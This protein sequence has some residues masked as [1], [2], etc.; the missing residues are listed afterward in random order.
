[1]EN[2]SKALIM[3]G[4][5][6]FTILVVGMM[7][8]FFSRYRELPQKQE[9]ALETEQV[10]KFN[11]EYESYNKKKMYG[12]DV[13]TIWNKAINNNK[14]YTSSINEKDYLEKDYLELEESNYYID[15][16][17]T[18]LTPV[19]SEATRYRETT[20]P[21]GNKMVETT[22]IDNG[23]IKGK[24]NGKGKSKPFDLGVVY[25]SGTPIHLLEKNKNKIIMYHKKMND[26]KDFETVKIQEDG[27]KF[28]EFNYTIVS[29]GFTSFKRKYFECTGV[30]Y[31][32]VTSRVSKIMFKEIPSKQEG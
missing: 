4:S 22:L 12:V 31:D 9:E 30:E 32:K 25:D 17:I 6:L 14:S 18:L 21:T 1:M 28:D 8:F 26:L 29:S 2:A 5:I 10:A 11:Q 27:T 20:N 24:V 7:M 13:V 3:A 23:T 16:E 19:I 15:V